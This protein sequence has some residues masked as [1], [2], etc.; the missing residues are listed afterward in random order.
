MAYPKIFDDAEVWND[1]LTK[2]ANG[3]SLSAILRQPNYPSYSWCKEK[4]R[5]DLELRRRYDQAVEDRGDRLAD[6][7]M[8]LAWTPM[9]EGMDGRTQS[10]WVNHLRLK[11]DTAKWVAS[12]LRP[13]VY[14]DKLEMSVTHEQISITKVLEEAKKRVDS[15]ANPKAK[16][17][18]D[19]PSKEV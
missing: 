7:L 14:G 8:E 9:P 5:E 19:V 13:R 10:A 4:L 15:I 17:V 3:N 6:E 2:M 1:I 16:E 11:I 18:I 12:K